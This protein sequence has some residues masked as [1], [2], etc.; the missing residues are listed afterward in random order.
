MARSRRKTPIWGITGARSEKKDKRIANRRLRR[1]VN[2]RLA[3]PDET[4]LPVLR[5]VSNPWSMAK[6]GRRWR[7]CPVEGIWWDRCMR[8]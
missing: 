4:P 7:S 1:A 3:Q 8:K 5:E 6:D 2:I